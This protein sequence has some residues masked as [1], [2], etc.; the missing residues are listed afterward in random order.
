MVLCR[1]VYLSIFAR[2]VINT[3][4]MGADQNVIDPAFTLSKE[5]RS[6]T[7]MKTSSRL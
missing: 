4:N 2:S 1:K 3:V 5:A 6:R 7:S